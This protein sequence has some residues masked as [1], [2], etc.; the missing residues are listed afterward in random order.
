VTAT[1]DAG[2]RR[3]KLSSSVRS[4]NFFMHMLDVEYLEGPTNTEAAQ[5]VSDIEVMLVLDI[6]GSM[7]SPAVAGDTKS[8]IAALRESATQFVEIVKANDSK[9]GVSIGI[10]PYASQV[11]IPAA[12]RQQFTVSKLSSWNGVANQGVPFINCIEIPASTYTSLA[13][14]RTTAYPMA[15]VADFGGVT[16]STDYLPVTDFP[17]ST[18]FGSSLCGTT[19]D[20]AT[21][22]SRNE[23]TDNHVMLPT[24]DP[25]PVI[26][27]I[28]N[29]TAAG[30]TSIAIGMRWGTALIDQSARP[31]YTAL[32]DDTVQGR[33]ADNTDTKT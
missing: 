12:L 30:N 27:A 6:T 16:A 7:S 9:N 1:S 10:V 28:G 13:L 2:L 23:A 29:L 5:G 25:A 32:G 21:T 24:K 8:K 20:S 33:P 17:V 22:P 11:N 4:E 19:P 15:A 14:S 18:V 31:I 26:T 3:V